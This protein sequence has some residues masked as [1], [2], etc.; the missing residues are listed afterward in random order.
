MVKSNKPG[1]DNK[2]LPP[3]ATRHEPLPWQV[4]KHPAEDPD[5]PARI[6]AILDSPSS[7]RS[8]LDPDFLAEYPV[9]GVPL[10]IDYLKPELL[11][12]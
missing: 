7:R 3:A 10:Q 1:S 6:K 2:P 12:E 5:A 9:R 4:P 11:L 8:D